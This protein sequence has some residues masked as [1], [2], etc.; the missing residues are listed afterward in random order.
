ME[1]TSQ[2]TQLAI[3]D[4]GAYSKD[5]P[6][7]LYNLLPKSMKDALL[8]TRNSFLNDLS[9]ESQRK[10]IRHVP[11]YKIV[12]RIRQSFWKEYDNA[13]ARN[14]NMLMTNVWQGI[15][16]SSGQFYNLFKQEHLAVF[17]FTRPPAKEAL[18]RAILDEA[19]EQIEDILT[20]DHRNKDG[21]INAFVAKLKVDIFK[22]FDDRVHGGVVKRV[23]VKSDVKQVNV[24]VDTNKD[25]LAEMK[26]LEDA[27]KRLE[28][29]RAQTPEL[30]VIE[31]VATQID[32]EDNDSDD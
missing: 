23:E 10:N 21:S 25:E 29:L 2:D 31:A 16:M 1:E 14:R 11:E 9:P 18:E 17:I 12:R 4:E 32:E 28:E 6:R 26:R 19:Y 15:C 7:S 24:N 3:A 22:H 13:L 5:N 8:R 30:D 27:K 20:C